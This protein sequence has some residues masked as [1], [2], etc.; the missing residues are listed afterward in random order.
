VDIGVFKVG[1]GITEGLR[2]ELMFGLKVVDGEDDVALF[3]EVSAVAS[4]VGGDAP[5]IQLG[6]GVEEDIIGRGAPLKDLEEP[7]GEDRRYV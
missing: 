7:G 2:K 3:F 5:V 1:A 4:N 6:G